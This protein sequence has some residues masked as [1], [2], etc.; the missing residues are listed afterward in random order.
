MIIH[1]IPWLIKQILLYKNDYLLPY[2][3]SK[4]KTGVDISQFVKKKK[5]KRFR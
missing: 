2:S 3:R 4:N 1:L 5:K